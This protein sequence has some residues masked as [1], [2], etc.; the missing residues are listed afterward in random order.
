MEYSMYHTI[1]AKTNSSISKVID[2]YK[3]GNDIIV[4]YHDAKGKPVSY[5]HLDVYK[6]QSLLIDTVRT[7]FLVVLSILGPIAFAFSV[8]DGFQSTLSQWFT[9]YISVYLWLPVSDL[10]SCM[11]ALSLIHI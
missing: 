1:A 3:K 2:K 6:R 7:F 5:T 10:F 4:P 9:R 11:L 8:R